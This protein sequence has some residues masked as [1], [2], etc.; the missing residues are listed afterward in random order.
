MEIK[1]D[2]KLLT[3]SWYILL[4]LSIF[5]VILTL[6]LHLI[7]LLD[8]DVDFT[9]FTKIV[10][11]VA[12]LSIILMWIVSV[13]II[14]LWI[15]NLSYNIEDDKITI[16]KGILTK[17]QQNIPYR[18]ITDFMLERTLF[19]RWLKIGSIKIQTAGQTQN[20]SGYEGTL[21]GLT[22]W[23]NLHEKLRTKLGK[24]HPESEKNKAD[25]SSV[26]S[27]SI[28]KLQ[29]ILE[30]LQKIRSTFEKSK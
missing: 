25:E 15:K 17:I 19:D 12:I 30:E 18:M 7:P 5:I 14:K 21:A 2:K 20:T 24:L 9:P 11:I 4:V 1:P 22:E 28:D 3:K 10:W 27:Q 13:P 23:D 6:I 8:A 26:N 29:L 16:N